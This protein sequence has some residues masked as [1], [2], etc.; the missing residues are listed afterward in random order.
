MIGVTL[1]SSNILLLNIKGYGLCLLYL[2]CIHDLEEFQ[3]VSE[4]ALGE[5]KEKREFFVVGLLQV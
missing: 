5:D 1:V 4:E 3:G 2:A